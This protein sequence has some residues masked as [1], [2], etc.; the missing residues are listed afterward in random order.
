MSNPVTLAVH[1]LE[2]LLE[3]AKA[4]AEHI[5]H[6][7]VEATPAAPAAPAVVAPLPQAATPAKVAPVARPAGVKIAGQN[8]AKDGLTQEWVERKK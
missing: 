1:E 2:A 4:A 3:K 8:Y 6:P 7:T 5:I